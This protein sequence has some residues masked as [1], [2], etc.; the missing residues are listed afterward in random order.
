MT[1]NYSF[2]VTFAIAGAVLLVFLLVFIWK[3]TRFNPVYGGALG[4]V[5]G[6]AG[7]IAVLGSA[8]H[9]YIVTGDKEYSHYALYGDKDYKLKNG[10][11]I[12]M[13][14][15]SSRALLINDTKGMLEV[16]EITY[17]AFAFPKT[18]VVNGFSTLRIGSSTIDYLF[19]N[20]PPKEISS[21]SGE[22]TRLWVK[23]K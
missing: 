15:S 19:D 5:M 2:L 20:K 17:G 3:K 13:L 4:V 21:S 6:F 18:T 12:K 14:S 9:V 8:K 10:T 11:P 7:V 16:K 22:E 23:R 1:L